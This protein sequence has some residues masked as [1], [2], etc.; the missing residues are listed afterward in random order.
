[1]AG[2]VP[3]LVLPLHGTWLDLKVLDEF[4]V[5][6]SCR[7]RFFGGFGELWWCECGRP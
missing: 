5:W 2:L 1:M 3:V 4:L 6:M 7:R